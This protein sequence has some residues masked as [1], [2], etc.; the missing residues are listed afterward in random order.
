M[1]HIEST[2]PGSRSRSSQASRDDRRRPSADAERRDS[3]PEGLH[4]S[5]SKGRIG[6]DVVRVYRTDA[7]LEPRTRVEHRPRVRSGRHWARHGVSDQSRGGQAISGRESHRDGS[8][9]SALASSR[10]KTFTGTA[11]G[12]RSASRRSSNVVRTFDSE[13]ISSFSKGLAAS[14]DASSRVVVRSPLNVSSYSSTSS[15]GAKSWI[16][17]MRVQGVEPRRLIAALSPIGF[18]RSTTDSRHQAAPEPWPPGEG[19]L[20]PACRDNTPNR[21]PMV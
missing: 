20:R 3:M 4:A 11:N 17:R 6:R 21:M 13:T 15:S 10:H 2:H 8:I 16:L 9:R 14:A 7:A 5:C 1:P 19:H 18:A 12:F